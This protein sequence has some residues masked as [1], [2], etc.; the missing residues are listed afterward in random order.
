[1]TGGKINK[2]QYHEAF[3]FVY[4]QGLIS[5]KFFQTLQ[6]LIL[7]EISFQMLLPIAGSV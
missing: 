5:H 7:N 6:I 4:E 3:F 2:Q 1:M